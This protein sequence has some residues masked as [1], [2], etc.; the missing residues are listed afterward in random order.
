MTGGVCLY[1]SPGRVTP[2]SPSQTLKIKFQCDNM[3]I[4]RKREILTQEGSAEIG[5]KHQFSEEDLRR[6][7]KFRLMDDDFMSKCFEDHIECTELV[8]RIV[9]EREDLNNQ[10]RTLNM[11]L[12]A[13]GHKVVI[14][15]PKFSQTPQI[16][17]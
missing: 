1:G 5:Q 10:F 6:L 2:S 9:L 13:F 14:H 11:I 4:R 15:Q 7:R 8:V 17:F 16:F 3:D 12:K